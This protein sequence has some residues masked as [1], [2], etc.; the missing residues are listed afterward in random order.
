MLR[1]DSEA[2]PEGKG[3]ITL[4]VL[5]GGT[6][7][8]DL[9]CIMR[10]TWDEVREENGL[11]KPEKSKEMR[12]TDQREASLEQDARQPNIAMEADEPANTKTRE[13]TEGAATA[14]QAMHG[15]SFSA[16]R[17][18]P[19][20]KTTSAS[21]GM[22]AE[23][24]AL[25]CRDDV[26]VE[27]RAA[28]LKSCLLSLEMCSPTAADG[29]LPTGEASTATFKCHEEVLYLQPL[30]PHKRFHAQKVQAHSDMYYL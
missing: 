14:V 29:S 19:G 26:V 2:V 10:E 27:D 21:F 24:P 5:P 30:I 22:K 23:H 12:A 18:D 3:S 20:P 6:S 9:R 7:L 4:Y 17:L 16:H 28:A 11:K 25:P 13:R 1:K 15:D 8:E